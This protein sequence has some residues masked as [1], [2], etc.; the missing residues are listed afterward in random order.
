MYFKKRNVSENLKCMYHQCRADCI[1]VNHIVIK[2]LRANIPAALMFSSITSLDLSSSLSFLN[3]RDMQ[4]T[5]DYHFSIELSKVPPIRQ[6]LSGTACQTAHSIDTQD[7]CD[8][9]SKRIDK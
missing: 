9:R 6:I 7:V 4:G 1:F 5:N 8:L 3:Y 2:R